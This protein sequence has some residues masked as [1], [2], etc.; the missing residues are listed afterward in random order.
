LIE[1]Q[2]N[3][4]ENYHNLGN[5]LIE[6]ENFSEGISALYYAIKLNPSSSISYLKLAEILAKSG[7]L[8]EAINAYQKVISSTPIW[9][10][11]ISIWVIF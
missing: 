11:L 9:L 8:S 10:R 7:K 5:I 4:W 1:I 6:Q 2:P 3:I